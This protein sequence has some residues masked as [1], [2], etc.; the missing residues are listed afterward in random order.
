MILMEQECIMS[1]VSNMF[2]IFLLGDDIPN[3]F[4][5]KDEGPLVC[6]EVPIIALNVAGF[7]VCTI[8]SPCASNDNIVSQIFLAFQL[9]IIPR[10]LVRPLGK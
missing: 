4:I 3:S 6:F 5:Y 1:G 9:S 10:I 7:V 8:Y 2:S